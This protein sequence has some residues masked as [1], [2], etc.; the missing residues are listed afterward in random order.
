MPYTL[1][2]TSGTPSSVSLNPQRSSFSP[3]QMVKTMV[4]AM[5]LI[6]TRI[7][8]ALDYN[9]AVH[10]FT[11]VQNGVKTS[12]ETVQTIATKAQ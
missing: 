11:I 9:T 4:A 10:A 8:S 6:L 1:V 7:E 2:N 12:A 5:S 3:P